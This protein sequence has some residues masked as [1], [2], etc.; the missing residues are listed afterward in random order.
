MSLAILLPK[1]LTDE[2]AITLATWGL[3]LVTFFLVVLTF[4]LWLDSWKKGREQRA[5]WDS[6]DKQLEIDRVELRTRWEREDG[7]RKE[8]NKPKYAVGFGLD[9]QSPYF[10][11]ANIGTRSFLIK[12]VFVNRK[13][14]GDI[15]FIPAPCKWNEVVPVGAKCIL[16]LERNLFPHD[17][18]KRT[19]VNTSFEC[20]ASCSIVDI[21]G[22][23]TSS[24]QYDFVIYAAP[25]G[26]LAIQA[27]TDY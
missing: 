1:F 23:Q 10:W 11:A 4:F 27:A 19:G 2:H 14:F 25:N 21:D 15:S 17:V 12:T 9:E 24:R 3:V 5:R 22:Q 7:I 6:E 18:A 8:E 13:V 20:N 16:Q 26:L